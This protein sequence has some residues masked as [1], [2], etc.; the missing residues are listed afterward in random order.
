MYILLSPFTF[1]MN[2]ESYHEFKVG[3]YIHVKVCIYC[4]P[5][6]S[7]NYSLVCYEMRLTY[8]SFD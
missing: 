3:V 6:V 8:K 5:K 1:H 2:D 7:N 4:V